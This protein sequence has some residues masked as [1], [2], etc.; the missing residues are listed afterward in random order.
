VSRRAALLLAWACPVTTILVFA[1]I[2]VLFMMGAPAPGIEAAIFTVFACVL[3]TVGALVVARVPS[4]P[5]GWILCGVA[6]YTSLSGLAE[7]YVERYL[8]GNGGSHGLAE[9]AAWFSNWAW[10][11]IVMVPLA[12]L[13]VY[14]PTGRPPSPRWR[15]VLWCA[16]I[17]MAAFAFSQAFDAGRLADY[18]RIVNPYGID[19]AAVEAASV[20]GLLVLGAVVASAASVV[21][22]FRSAIGVERQQIKWLAYAAS[23]A[24]GTF[25]LGFLIGSLWSENVAN[26]LIIAGVAGLPLAIS[27]A[28]LRY[29][30]YDID[31][32]INRTLV[33]GALTATLAGAYIGSVLL[34]QLVLSPGSDL[35]IAGSTL[36]VAALFRPARGRI[37]AVVD[38]R[39]YR[40]K[41]DAQRTLETFAG[42]V[43]DQVELDALSADLRRV[44]AETLQPAHVSLW[45]RETPR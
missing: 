42:R 29:R 32:V 37:Q 33:Y 8:A 20:G 6:L 40:R 24:S 4:N 35:A 19:H 11:P 5:I 17:G 31:V 7:G 44:I 2:G 12:F 9:A 45:L 41:Y 15:I 10:I 22:R 21:V 18:P 39:F 36:A 16:G 30:L 26:A 13:P 28:I 23:L 3:A 34:L 38:R 14:F 27:V 43:R 1:G 25:L